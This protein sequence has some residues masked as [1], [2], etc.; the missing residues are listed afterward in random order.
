MWIVQLA[1][2]RPYTFVIM[3]L[4]IVIMGGL[5]IVR[6]PTDIFPEIDIP[7]VS[8]IWQYAGVSPEEMAEV[9]TVR[10]ER[11]F[12]TSVN[13][14]EHMESQSLPGVAVI[15]VFFHPKAK[16]DAAV[17]QLTAASQSVLK[18]LP[19]GITPPSV[20]RFNAS[21]VPI[22]Q[23]GISSD[24]LPEQQLYDLGYNFIRTQMAN[25]QGASFP[26]PYGGRPRQISVDLNPQ[27]LYAQ[28]LSAG[29]VATAINNQSLILPS[30]TVKI[31]AQEYTVKLNSAPD[32]AVAFNRLPVRQTNGTTVYV[33]DVAHVRDGYAIQSNIVRHNG[34]RAALLTVLK[35]GGS[36]TLRIVS[37]IKEILP[38][39][40]ST[41][42]SALNLKLLFD[43]SV[44]VRAAIKGVLR[45]AIIAAFLTGMMI[46]LFLGSWRSTVIVCISIPLSILTSLAILSL[47]GETINVMTLGGMALAV[48]ILVDDATVEL[49]N[50]HRNMAMKK[51]LVRAVL[52]GA[53]QIAA[54]AFV[55][56]LSICI[57]FVPVLLLTGAAKFLFTPLALAVVFAM[58]AS[59]LLSRTLIPNMVHFMLKP[60]VKLYALGAHGES[61][62]GKGIIWRMHYLFN[63]RFEMMRASYTSLL[64]W[65]LDHRAP[66]L[67]G[68]GLFVAGSLCL[69]VFTGRDFFPT[70][71][72]GQMRLHAMAPTGTRIEET[73]ALFS[74]IDDEI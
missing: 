74:R 60:E 70:V 69:T 19:T 23:L 10:S 14:I 30:G 62:G 20:L 52:D 47:L 34:S 32:L 37:R 53:Q 49:E 2:R 25:V 63:R 15:K 8:V 40:R 16:I 4:L 46:L 1:L 72:S 50:T 5:A 42:P 54:P 35:N 29:D 71:D 38:R 43:Q 31:G 33:G 17:A 64:H 11:S 73:E 26:L 44:F 59:Y 41:L 22:L 9:I 18:S 28:N 6:M 7:V 68:F 13:D 24:S 58:M 21:A 65:A 36:S 55:S 12:T 3:A 45:E 51:P 48:G 61:A 27:A 56:T 39:I 67:T 66:V 57:V